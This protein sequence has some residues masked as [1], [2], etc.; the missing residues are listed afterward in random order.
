LPGFVLKSSEPGRAVFEMEADDDAL[1]L[2]CADWF[3]EQGDP[4][5]VARAEFTRT[6]V[7]RAGLPPP[8]PSPASSTNPCRR[9]KGALSRRCIASAVTGCPVCRSKGW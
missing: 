6:Q 1:R 2:A 3:E 5:S 8:T 9:S 4:A 7:V